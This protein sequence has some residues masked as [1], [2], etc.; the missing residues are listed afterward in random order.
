MI[1]L[2]VFAIPPTKGTSWVTGVGVTRYSKPYGR[3]HAKYPKNPSRPMAVADSRSFRGERFRCMYTSKGGRR[4]IGKSLTKAPSPRVAAEKS[5]RSDV[6]SKRLNAMRKMHT[7][8][9][10]PRSSTPKKENGF[11]N[12]T[13]PISRP[14]AGDFIFLPMQMRTII[15]ARSKRNTGRRK[16]RDNIVML[17]SA[18]KDAVSGHDLS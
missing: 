2:T 10:N 8:S 18:P 17:G 11:R 1:E 16:R 4:K 3:T 12:Q 13:N 15:V 7:T 9:G 14:S 6:N 5:G